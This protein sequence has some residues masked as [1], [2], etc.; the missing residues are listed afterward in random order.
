[1]HTRKQEGNKKTYRNI[2]LASQPATTAC[3]LL[4]RLSLK[5]VP[6]ARVLYSSSATFLIA[7]ASLTPCFR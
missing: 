1:M 6:S 2:V 3:A 5:T 7:N 4:V